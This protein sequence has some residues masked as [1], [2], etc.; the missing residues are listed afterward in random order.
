MAGGLNCKEDEGRDIGPLFLSGGAQRAIF[1]NRIYSDF[2][3]MMY[4]C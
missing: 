4:L 2:N 3:A 1:K